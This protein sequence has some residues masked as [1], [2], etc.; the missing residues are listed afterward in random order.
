MVGFAGEPI[1]VAF[2]GGSITYG[3]DVYLP[4]RGT[5]SYAGQVLTWINQTFPN[6]GHKFVIGGRGATE[7]TFFSACLPDHLPHEDVD[8]VMLEF[9]IND[10]DSHYAGWRSLNMLTA[11]RVMIH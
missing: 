6:A 2:L 9:N 4:R 8:L 10:M 11:P 1:S 5:E 7:S 3:G